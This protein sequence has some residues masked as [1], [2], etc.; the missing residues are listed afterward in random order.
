[1]A[2]TVLVGLLLGFVA[3]IPLA[4]PVAVLIL[5]RTVQGRTVTAVFIG[6]GSA[7]AEAVYAALAFWGFSTFLARF[8]WID[9]ASKVISAVILVLLGVS[10][11][12]GRRP[13]DAE[14]EAAAAAVGV[15]RPSAR[16]GGS[17][18]V[19]FAL[20][21]LNPTLL[22]TWAIV[23]T[24]LFSMEVVTFTPARAI[25]FGLA[26]GVGVGLWYFV[27]VE[28][29]T[30]FKSRFKPDVIPRVTRW[31]GF[32]FIGLGVYLGVRLLVR[33]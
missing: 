29:L 15:S 31:L 21:L 2:V 20:T 24:T 16:R 18:A 22:A 12:R 30:R 14:A 17:L 23:A 11:A 5:R 4:G 10:F 28:L 9:L 6:I 33:L 7:T 1:M 13:K 25:P 19:G 27:L 8:A 32:G 3:A 26:V